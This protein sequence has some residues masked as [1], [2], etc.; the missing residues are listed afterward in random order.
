M[1]LPDSKAVAGLQ[2]RPATRHFQGQARPQVA[3]AILMSCSNEQLPPRGKQRPHSFD[4]G[5]QERQG[6]QGTSKRRGVYKSGTGTFMF[7]STSMS[8]ALDNLQFYPK[9]KPSHCF[10][11]LVTVTIHSSA[12]LVRCV[13]SPTCVQCPVP[14]A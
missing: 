7:A 10:A 12:S 14:T 11:A 9:V 1:F 6:H 3:A 8:A 5:L 4:I 13:A 2:L